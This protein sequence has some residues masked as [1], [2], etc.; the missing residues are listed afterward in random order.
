MP[1][2]PTTRT[3]KAG[4]GRPPK[5][6]PH[7]RPRGSI[8]VKA[9]SR[10]AKESGAPLK[11]KLE[12]KEKALI[13]RRELAAQMTRKAIVKAAEARQELNQ[14][15]VGADHAC[16]RFM[17]RAD[18]LAW[19]CL[20]VHRTHVEE[21]VVQLGAGMGYEIAEVGTEEPQFR[22]MELL[23]KALGDFAPNVAVQV[24]Q[25]GDENPP[26]VVLMVMDNGRG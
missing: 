17:N 23:M 12:E 9:A 6:K 16:L 21:K 11:V 20:Q 8:G 15:Q 10:E 13:R 26:G 4:P 7:D 22:A 5:Q 14:E 25:N 19:L 3:A 18:R 1:E 24:N 2:T